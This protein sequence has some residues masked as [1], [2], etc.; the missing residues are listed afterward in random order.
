M[1][2]TSFD[3]LAHLSNYRMPFAIV[4]TSKNT[5]GEETCWIDLWTSREPYCNP[6]LLRLNYEFGLLFSRTRCRWRRAVSSIKL[7]KGSE[8][9][10]HYLVRL[11]FAGVRCYGVSTIAP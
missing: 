11:T 1:A 6:E 8:R 7:I 2:A 10:R 9:T 3:I 4:H 5:C